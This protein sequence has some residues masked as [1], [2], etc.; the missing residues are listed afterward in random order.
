MKMPLTV[1]AV[2]IGAVVFCGAGAKRTLTVDEAVELSQ[3]TGR[4]IL[5]VA[6]QE[7]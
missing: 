2:T 6:G 1:L 7:T 4:P 5:A 3:K